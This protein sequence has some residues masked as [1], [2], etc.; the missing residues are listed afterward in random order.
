MRSGTSFFSKTIFLKNVKRFWPLWTVYLIILILLIPV[1]LANSYRYSVD[2]SGISSA[3]SVIKNAQNFCM[4]LTPIF[5]GISALAVHS[6]LYN[7]RSAGMMASLP[8]KRGAM[9]FTNYISGLVWTCAANLI[10]FLAAAAAG[11]AYGMPVTEALLG[12]LGINTLLTLFFYGFACFC[13][14]LTGSIVTMPLLYIVINFTAVAVELTVD[15]ILNTCLYGISF[16]GNL[17]LRFLSPAVMLWN[18]KVSLI[19]T[20]TGAIVN[21]WSLSSQDYS[22]LKIF[23]EGAGAYAVYAAA[24]IVFAVLAGMIFRRRHMETASD[25]VAVKPLRPLF[26]YCM[27]FGC[28]LVLGV[29]LYSTAF[30]RMSAAKEAI[31]LTLL[32]LTGGFIGYFASEMM[33]QKSFRVFKGRWRGFIISALIIVVSMTVVESDILG[34]EKYVPGAESVE[35]IDIFADGQTRIIQPG[36]IEKT[37]ELHRSLINNKKV[38]EAAQDNGYNEV[39]Y[40]GESYGS[41]RVS[42]EYTLKSG[43]VVSRT[44]MIPVSDRLLKEPNSD[45][46]LLDSIVN[47]EEAIKARKET[48]VEV[49]ERNIYSARINGISTEGRQIQTELTK[50]QALELYD[51]ILRDMDEG[52]IG[53]IW[54][55][56]GAEYEATVFDAN[57]NFDLTE[58]VG[59]A[60]YVSDRFWTVP[61]K[62]SSWTNGYLKTLGIEFMTIAESNSSQNQKEKFG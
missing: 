21:T 29:A 6:Y 8:I 10:V 57:I 3:F 30:P 15:K 4:V 1:N 14:V 50:Y 22:G 34:L 58:L 54:L 43:R 18:Q 19:D 33:L 24:G 36:N 13:A 26:R 41:Q 32:M 46:N 12:W 56:G 20:A 37:L 35:G 9:F 25:V 5:S 59:D 45:A 31:Y 40:D 42:L 49:N 7:S 38:Y 27:T 62:D 55:Y 47:S 17:V 53:R 23:F 61:T 16:S 28:A 60:Q 2:R 52:T 44:Y 39:P 51:C 11:A 48:A